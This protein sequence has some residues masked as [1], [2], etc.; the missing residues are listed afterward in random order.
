MPYK[1]HF[2]PR[3]RKK[4]QPNY[5]Q[6][7]NFLKNDLYPLDNLTAFCFHRRG[8]FIIKP[9]IL[10]LKAIL[11]RT[12]P[13]AILLGV[14]GISVEALG[15][16]GVAPSQTGLFFD[17][18][19][20]RTS[21]FRNPTVDE[22]GS[23]A[24]GIYD[25]SN[26]DGVY[27][28]TDEDERPIGQR[29]RIFDEEGRPIGAAVYTTTSRAA[30]D[31]TGVV[32]AYPTTGTYFAP[33][34]IT[35][36]FLAGKRNIKL[37]PVNIGLG[38]QSNVE[39][40]DNVTRRNTDKLDEV[41]AGVMLNMDM[42][43]Q[44]TENNRL[45]LT[46]GVGVDHYFNHPE[47]SPN[48]NELVLNVLPGT[49]LAFDVMV[50]DIVFV[51]YDRVSVRPVAQNDFGL[52]QNEIFGSVQNDAGVAMNWA[53]NSSTTL[54]LNFNRS[55]AWALEDAFSS[56][57]RVINSISGSL[58]WTPS[59]TYTVGVEGSF[60]WID[61]KNEF[62]NDGTTASA[63]VFFIMPFSQNTIMKASA[64]YQVF[65]FDS[66]P[67]FSRQFSEADILQTQEQLDLVN[68]LYGQL[69]TIQDPVELE[70][71]TA[72]L[73]A[74]RQD[75]ETLL[76]FQRLQKQRDDDFE[77]S[78]SFD[79]EDLSD[80]Y[81]NVTLYNR[82]NSRVSHQ[83]AFGHESSLNTTSNFITADY[84]SYGVGVVAWRG[85]QFAFSTY[86]ERGEESGGRLAEDTDQ[87]GF[88]VFYG[89]RL[90][91]RIMLGLGYHYGNTDSNV[92][93]RDYEQHAFTVDLNYSINAK[94][95]MGLG[96]RYYTTDAEDSELSFDQNRII[97]SLNYN[98]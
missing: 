46:M 54:S 41:I 65:D 12:A 96:Y 66:P 68:Q 48:G 23:R 56:F 44:I 19:R 31:Y 82:I 34:Y 6:G 5:I 72:E 60:S 39:Y 63:G 49:T 50:G 61:Y 93:N 94:L 91:Q 22:G 26:E 89:H 17:D 55:D 14:V 81:Y 67:Q 47:V 88:D 78:R 10:S 25:Y 8:I 80:Y 79:N 18:L 7:E 33:T 29:S 71:R 16:T 13:L 11:N 73:D 74:A 92:E 1:G 27:V 42:N 87:F 38:M 15:Q 75:L 97:M 52:D 59:G 35:D 51:F 57:D 84:I 53:V 20:Y 4:S 95:N 32:G 70:R 21:T 9:M 3:L 76:A 36:P 43:W 86:F 58:A 28:G 30:G 77:N 64:G 83:L 69:F 90:T 98:F 37:G 40:N 24:A 62:N 85:G 2:S 45:S